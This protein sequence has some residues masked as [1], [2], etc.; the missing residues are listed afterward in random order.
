MFCFLL[1]NKLLANA[2]QST[3]FQHYN[4]IFAPYC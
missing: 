1:V 2:G 3:D 4:R